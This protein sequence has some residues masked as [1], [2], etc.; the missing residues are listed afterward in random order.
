SHCFLAMYSARLVSR[1][2]RYLTKSTKIDTIRQ[3]DPTTKYDFIPAEG[4]DKGDIVDVILKDFFTIEPHS[5]ALGITAETGGYFVD[6]LVSKCLKY[7]HS[8]RI[9]H[10][11]TGKLIGVRLMSAWE[12]GSE[13]DFDIDI[14]Q[15]DENNRIIHTILGN[16]KEDFWRLRPEAQKVLR[17]ELSFVHSDHQRQG[18]AQHLVHLGL[19]YDLLRSKGFDGIMS[20]A[21]SIANQKLLLKNGY[22][23]LAT[24]KQKE[25]IRSNG[26]PVIFPD[27]T[28]A[29]KLV[30]FNLKK[31]SNA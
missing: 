12:R 7:P 10:K 30:Y 17:R 13:D 2:V 21:S 16:L 20:E 15:L 18:I 24:T 25:Y 29:V 11:S 9:L 26:E 6:W 28:E 5:R 4:R 31:A 14:E 3:S 22:E 23:I 27:E 1:H 19:D 8:Y